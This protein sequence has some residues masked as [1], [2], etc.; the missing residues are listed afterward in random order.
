[1]KSIGIQ[2]V[3]RFPFPTPPEAS[4]VR[5]AI[6]LLKVRDLCALQLLFCH[7]LP[8]PMSINN[9]PR[10]LP[11]YSRLSCSPLSSVL[12]LSLLLL[13]SIT[14]LIPLVLSSLESTSRC[15]MS[16][17]LR[18]IG[19]TLPDIQLTS[20]FMFLLY[21]LRRTR[22]IG[23]RMFSDPP[24]AVARLLLVPSASRRSRCAG[25][26]DRYW[27]GGGTVPNLRTICEDASLEQAE[28]LPGVHCHTG[29]WA[30]STA[31]FLEALR[32]V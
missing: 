21:P 10:P 4:A 12:C 26:V 24:H 1:M 30:H 32:P 25:E 28:R 29:C 9:A 19:T 22:P 20:V 2:N 17:P 31:A 5:T 27:K 6:R 14:S 18:Y 11:E 7:V 15:C 8:F 23:Y 16:L 3:I 13:C